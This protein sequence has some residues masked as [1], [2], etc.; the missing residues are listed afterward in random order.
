MKKILKSRKIIAVLLLICLAFVMTGCSTGSNLDED[1][2]YIVDEN[3][4]CAKIVGAILTFLQ[5]ILSK[6]GLENYVYA[7]AA[8]ALLVKVATTPLNIK[9]QKSMKAMQSLN[10]KMQELNEKYA[11]DPQKKQIAMQKLYQEAG[12]SPVSGCL[13]I[14]IQMPIL[15]IL[16]YGIRNWVPDAQIIAD[17]LY[18]FFWINDLSLTVKLTPYQWFF[19]IVCALVTVGQQIMSVSN[20]KDQTQ[21]MMLIMMPA[22]FLFIT[23]QFPS[24]LAVYWL[25][26]GLFTMIQST[27]LNYRLKTGFFLPKEEKERQREIAAANKAKMMNKEERAK[28]RRE[29]GLKHQPTHNMSEKNSK[30]IADS[31]GRKRNDNRDKPWH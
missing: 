28:Q 23:R 10:P 18:S 3:S 19:P 24:G 27:W 20:F 11:D 29:A 14:L 5:A 2:N 21:R 31:E 9:Q 16:F 25:F 1:G 12:T 6:I 7:I 17:G 13:P 8:M 30:V 22:M 4:T 15:F 26:Y